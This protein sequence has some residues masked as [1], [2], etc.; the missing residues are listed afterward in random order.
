MSELTDKLKKEIESARISTREELE[1]FRLTYLSKK[2]HVSALLSKIGSVAAEERKIFG[3]KVNAVKQLAHTKLKEAEQRL[4]STKKSTAKATDDITLPASPLPLG[5]A[6][7]LS[8]TLRQI[9]DVFYRLGFS[10]ADGPEVEDDFHNFTALNFPPEHPA[11]DMQDTFFIR[12]TEDAD[13]DDLVLRTHTSP[14]QIRL[15]KNGTPPFRSIMPGRVY[16][17]E[18]ITAK[19]YCLFHQVEGLYVDKKVS[20]AELKDTLIMFVEMIYGEDVRY[21]IRPSF[22][23]FTEPSLEMDIWWGDESSGKWLEILGA[24]MVHPNVLQAVGIDSEEYSGFA[25]GMGVER[26]AM[27]KYGIDDIRLLY[28]NDLRFLQ[29]FQ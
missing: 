14:V 22:F 9:K 2:G 26:I 29:Q 5:V 3:Q 8:Q 1:H 21:R 20:L 18:S 13:T 10:I 7:P 27:L 28:D 16:R 23:P 24:G 17:N 11:R 6:H 19:S 25:F 4:H 12:K 15:M